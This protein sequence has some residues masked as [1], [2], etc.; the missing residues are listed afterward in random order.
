[1]R[2]KWS[3]PSLRKVSKLFFSLPSKFTTSPF[4]VV[5]ALLFTVLWA[6]KETHGQY[7]LQ[8]EKVDAAEERALIA[9]KNAA[10]TKHGLK[11]DFVSDEVIM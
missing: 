4:S 8:G 7:P 1:M 6:W 5:T 3:Q 9:Q 10:L 11:T 2:V